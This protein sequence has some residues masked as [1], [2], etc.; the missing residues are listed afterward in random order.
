MQQAVVWV[1]QLV[2]QSLEQEL[3]LGFVELER[4]VQLVVH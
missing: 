2:E 1:E 3:Q 4:R